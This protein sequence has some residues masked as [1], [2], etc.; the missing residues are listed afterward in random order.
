MALPIV[1]AACDAARELGLPEARIVLA[2]AVILVATAPKSNSAICG[3]D[4][5]MEDLRKT[6]GGDIPAHLRDAHYEGAKDLGHGLTY[7]YPHSFENAWTKQQY[8]PDELRD[9]IYY[10]PGD[11]KTEQAAAEYWKKIKGGKS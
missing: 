7:Q 3:I 1:K 11:N 8:L 9:R 6:G 2:E 4:A 10:K 5:A